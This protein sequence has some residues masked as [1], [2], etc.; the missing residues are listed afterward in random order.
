MSHV[1]WKRLLTTLVVFLLL[2]GIWL[3]LVAPEFYQAQLGDRLAAHW[4]WSAAVA[5]YL[6]LVLGL[7]EFVVTPGLRSGSLGRAVARGGLFGLVAYGT[8]DL[9]NLATLAEW[10][11]IVVL[12]DMAW[13][14]ILCA[15]VTLVSVAFLRLLPAGQPRRR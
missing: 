15:L 9:T 11:L 3:G 14:T 6:L 10:P 13:G 12:V 5:V 7:V 8:Y 1:F 4:N 2:D